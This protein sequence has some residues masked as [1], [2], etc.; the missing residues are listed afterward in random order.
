MSVREAFREG[1]IYLAAGYGRHC[2]PISRAAFDAAR[3]HRLA[4]TAENMDA[5]DRS[6]S[7]DAGSPV[8]MRFFCCIQNNLMAYSSH[9]SCSAS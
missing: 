4:K 8:F 9:G 7:D 6:M 1:P 5:S 2:L 3:R